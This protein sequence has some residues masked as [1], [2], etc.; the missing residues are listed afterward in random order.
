MPTDISST[1]AVSSPAAAVLVTWED[2]DTTNDNETRLTGREIILARN[3]G[4]NP[5]SVTI[6]SVSSPYGRTGDITQAVAGGAMY[7]FGPFGQTEAWAQTDG[8]IYF[9]AD[10]DEVEFAVIRLPATIV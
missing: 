2:A 6:T 5:H 4:S 10:D 3:T 7:V 9:E 1:D 8:T